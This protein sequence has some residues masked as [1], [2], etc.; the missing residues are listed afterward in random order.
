MF[1]FRRKNGRHIV[2]HHGIQYVFETQ[3]DAMKFIKDTTAQAMKHDIGN[4]ANPVGEEGNNDG[5]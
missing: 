1:K 5:I 3:K 4:K 2:T